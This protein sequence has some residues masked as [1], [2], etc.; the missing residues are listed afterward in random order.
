MVSQSK[1]QENGVSD[2]HT[3]R[4]RL[5]VILASDNLSTG[6]AEDSIY[7]DLGPYD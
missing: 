5:L 4:C 7:T 1:K 6:E 3:C 2:N